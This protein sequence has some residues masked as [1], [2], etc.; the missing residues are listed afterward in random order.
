[1]QRLLS[2]LTLF[3]FLSLSLTG[4]ARFQDH[5]LNPA[6]S[7]VRIEARNKIASN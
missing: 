3:A 2:I 4:C 5:P 1:M 7:A 6:E